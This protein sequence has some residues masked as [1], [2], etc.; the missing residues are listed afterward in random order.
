MCVECLRNIEVA[1]KMLYV[2]KSTV[3]IGS[4]LAVLMNTGTSVYG[5]AWLEGNICD[6]DGTYEE[7]KRP[8]PIKSVM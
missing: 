6:D 5:E 1:R 2:V 8:I 3:L 4:G 7:K